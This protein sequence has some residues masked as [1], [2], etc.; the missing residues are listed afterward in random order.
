[1]NALDYRMLHGIVF[2]S[3]YPGYRPSVRELPNG[4]GYVDDGK[5]YAHVAAKYLTPTYCAKWPLR[6]R[7][8]DGVLDEAHSLAT[9]VA[10]ALRVPARLMPSRQYSA[11]RVLEYPAGAG[12][13]E[14]TDFDL[15]TLMLYRDQ[16][17]KFLSDW[18][19]MP[20]SV[21]ALNAQCHLGEIA[22]M[23]GIG[24]A[25]KHRVSPSDR[26]QHSI[27]YFA[28]PNHDA[29]V[30]GTQTIGQWLD[31]RMTRSRVEAA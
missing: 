11:L 26:P 1:M 14:H 23:A 28:I 10:Q 27:V 2:Q 30:P 7:Y 4:D 24:R 6:A 25:T 12:S 19:E 15:F 13:H 16:P 31:E 18:H 17:S 21:R 22:E 29:P 5:Q 20:E 3:D 8:L 9:R